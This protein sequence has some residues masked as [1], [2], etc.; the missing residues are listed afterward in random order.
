MAPSWRLLPVTALVALAVPVTAPAHTGGLELSA[1]LAGSAAYPNAAG[2]STLERS[3]GK[4]EIDVT[5]THVARLAGQRLVVFVD[6]K[7]V[8]TLRVSAAGRAHR[9]WETNH[10][11][12]VPRASAGDRVTVRTTV[13]RLVVRGTY[14]PELED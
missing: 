2:R 13:G 8:G 7:R 6:G 9:S 4:R 11:Q 5:V 1:R 14:H 10:G 3:S 12:F